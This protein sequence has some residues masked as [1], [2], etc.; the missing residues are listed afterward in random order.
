MIDAKILNS[1]AV[2]L[3]P[4]YGILLWHIPDHGIIFDAF[5]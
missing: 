5:S 3:I 2:S 1:K 4:D